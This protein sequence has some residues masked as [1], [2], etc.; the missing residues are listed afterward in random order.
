MSSCLVCV[1]CVIILGS[2]FSMLFVVIS[3]G[4]VGVG[5]RNSIGMSMSLVGR[6]SLG[7]IWKCTWAMSV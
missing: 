5:S 6:V 4:M 3:S 7:L 1:L 2:L